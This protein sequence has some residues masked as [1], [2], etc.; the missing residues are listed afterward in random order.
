MKPTLT[1][2]L[3]RG[4]FADAMLDKYFPL[5]P[6]KVISDIGAGFGHMGPKINSIGG[7]WQPFDYYKKMD[8]SIVWDLNHSYPKETA[9]AGTVV[10]L[11]VLE[12]LANPLLGI[13]H[14]AEH[15]E[16]RGYLILTTPNP[17]S[18]QNRLHLLRKGL[19]YAFQPKHLA[20]HHVFTPWEHVVRFFM[21]QQGLEILEYAIVDI[22]YQYEKKQGIK[23]KFLSFICNIIEKRDPKAAG[24]SYGLVARKK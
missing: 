14:I 20:E 1:K 11:E 17:Q 8:K 4:A 10:F 3:N 21:E 24:M 5:A 19:L 9:K 7:T 16:P 2:Y 22:Q 18:A 12:H 13:S 15:L 23:A 6:T